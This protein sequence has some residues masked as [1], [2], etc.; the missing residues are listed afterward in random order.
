MS[1]TP[2]DDNTEFH[3]ELDIQKIIFDQIIL[4]NRMRANDPTLY[5]DC[6]EQLNLLLPWQQQIEVEEEWE[7]YTIETKEWRAALLDG[8]WGSKDPE[9]PD[10]INVPGTLR[11]NPK[12]ND[13]KPK[14]ISPI[15]HE[16]T[17]VDPALKFKT[18]MRKLQ[19]IGYTHKTDQTKSGG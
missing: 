9:K 10:M 4:C 11:Y 12:F 7:D 14:Q 1:K 6:V 13:G 3:G 19:G 2:K 15:W 18:I 16:A 5:R 8:E 17:E